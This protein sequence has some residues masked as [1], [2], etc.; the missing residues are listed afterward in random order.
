MK[1]NAHK[2]RRRKQISLMN[3]ILFFIILALVSAAIAYFF[4][5]PNA[6]PGN[7]PHNTSNQLNQTNTKLSTRS[8]NSTLEGSWL[9]MMGGAILDIHGQL[10]RLEL[11]SVDNHLLRRGK[12]IIQ[13]NTVTFIDLDSSSFC[14]GK[15]GIYSFERKKSQLILKVKTDSCPGRAERLSTDWDSI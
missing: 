7:L 10:Y 15:L 4:T 8:G 13:G 9:N 5:R 1:V 6:Q 3:L 2:K 12:V 14:K 11:P